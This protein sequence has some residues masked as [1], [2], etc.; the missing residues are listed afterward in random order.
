MLPND[1]P[2]AIEWRHETGDDRGRLCQIRHVI[3]IASSAGAPAQAA[4]H[5]CESIKEFKAADMDMMKSMEGAT[6]R[7]KP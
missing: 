1:E 2:E 4:E 5:A 7:R 6:Y 3:A